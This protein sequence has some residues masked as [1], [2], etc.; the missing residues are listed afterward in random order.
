MN[1]SIPDVEP[2]LKALASETR[3]KMLF[4]V[5]ADGRECTV[6]QVAEAMGLS[7]STTSEH[8]AILKRGGIL[9]SRREGKETYYRPDRGRVLAMLRQLTEL[10]S[11]C[12]PLE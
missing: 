5:F 11:S 6:G 3:Q 2:F 1:P 4:G 9:E 7:Q 8:L 10:L 12:C